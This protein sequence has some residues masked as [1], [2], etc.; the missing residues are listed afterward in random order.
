MSDNI[1]NTSGFAC[2]VQE[3]IINDTN[4]NHCKLKKRYR[5]VESVVTAHNNSDGKF[6]GQAGNRHLRRSCFGVPNETPLVEAVSQFS[7]ISLVARIQNFGKIE[8]NFDNI[9][10]INKIPTLL[11]MP[12]NASLD[13]IGINMSEGSLK[14]ECETAAARIKPN[15]V[16]YWGEHQ[17]IDSLLFENTDKDD[18]WIR[19]P[20]DGKDESIEEFNQYYWNSEFHYA[21]LSNNP[22]NLCNDCDLNCKWIIERM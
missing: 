13:I 6:G 20:Y 1:A 2:L 18:M 12:C 11:L 19:C 16:F 5:N 14:I 7:T 21:S 9:N 10:D 8:L 22:K 3:I 15:S 4:I 17:F